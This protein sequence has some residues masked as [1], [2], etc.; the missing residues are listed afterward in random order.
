MRR[1]VWGALL[2]VVILMG[3]VPAAQAAITPCADNTNCDPYNSDQTDSSTTYGTSGQSVI[4]RADF[5]KPS[6]YCFMPTWVWSESKQAWVAG[7][8][9]RTYTSAGYCTCNKTTGALGGSCSF[10]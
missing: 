10:R 5:N 7:P 6:T 2:T 1:T 8:C 9:S 4:C 3:V